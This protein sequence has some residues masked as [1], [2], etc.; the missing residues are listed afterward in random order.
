MGRKNRSGLHGLVI[1]IFYIHF[2]H[3]F[4]YSLA[5]FRVV[6]DLTVPPGLLQ[7]AA[8][9]SEEEESG[10]EEE[11]AVVETAHRGRWSEGLNGGWRA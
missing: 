4:F 9:E 5:F 10:E 3:S 2:F 1:G 7:A 6:P 8:E 11:D